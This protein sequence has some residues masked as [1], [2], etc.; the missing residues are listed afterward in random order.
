VYRTILFGI[1]IGLILTFEC[2]GQS[3]PHSAPHSLAF[4]AGPYDCA[5]A[6]PSAPF[7]KLILFSDGH[8][9]QRGFLGS[10]PH[11]VSWIAA[12]DR[13]GEFRIPTIQFPHGMFMV[14][15]D[16]VLLYTMEPG[17]SVFGKPSRFDKKVPDADLVLTKRF[18]IMPA[19]GEWIEV[20]PLNSSRLPM[21]C[22]ASATR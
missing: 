18:Q 11:K 17:Y 12:H 9:L 21:K 13:R 15:R 3:P 20:M 16:T 10:I 6:S 7:S 8:W 22:K 5:P 14:Q 1:V 2:V 4:I 19:S